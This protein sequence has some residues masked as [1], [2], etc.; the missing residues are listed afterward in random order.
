M[1]STS[2]E[3][4]NLSREIGN[5]NFNDVVRGVKEDRRW[6]TKFVDGYYPQIF[7]YF[8]PGPGFGGSCF[9]KDVKALLSAGKSRGLNMDILDAIISVNNI[10]HDQIVNILEDRHILDQNKN[11]IILGLSFKENTDDIRFSKS[12]DLIK[13][14][15]DRATLF[16][17]DPM[18]IENVKDFFKD[19]D[20][21]TIKFVSNWRKAISR[22]DAAVIMT[23][24]ADYNEI[25]IQKIKD[26]ILL[27]DSR[28]FLSRFENEPNYVSLNN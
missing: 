4:A 2:N 25:S 8:K 14:L 19:D 3:L 10:Q 20:I 9:P 6:N 24:W 27:V 21:I 28:G 1:I 16:L 22:M 12:L 5:I 17:H 18:A 13:S 7:S 26:I 11:V 15:N 23:N